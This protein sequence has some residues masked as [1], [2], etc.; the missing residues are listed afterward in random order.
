MS[1][2]KALTAIGVAAIAAGAGTGTASAETITMKLATGH[3]PALYYVERFADY[4]APQFKA[5]VEAQT[6]HKVNVLELYSGTAVKVNETLEGLQNGIVDVGGVAYPF[7]ASK[8]PL[9]GF[10]VFLPF[11]PDDPRV[12]RTVARDVW[13]MIPELQGSLHEK[14]AQRMI[15]LVPLDPYEIV[16]RKPVRK[17]EDMKGL[18]MGLAGPNAFWFTQTGAVGVQDNAGSVYTGLQTGVIDASLAFA[19]L[20]WKGKLTDIAKNYTQLG[21][22]SMTWIGVHVS[23]RWY[24]GLPPEVQQV[25]LDLGR[26]FEHI[27]SDG[28][29]NAYAPTLQKM[30]DNGVTIVQ[31]PLEERRKWAE[32]LRDMPQKKADELEAEGWPAIATFNATL[33]AA[34]RHGHTWP[35]RYE[36][37]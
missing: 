22:S 31:L 17:L 3:P 21:I 10:Q 34:E 14:Y 19:S 8:L 35:V 24:D 12:S 9:H 5:R 26:D 11:S 29:T 1:I 2:R 25:L 27:V 15:T 16:S 4:F 32:S 37:K 6:D 30:R 20:V 28:I 13:G 33:D 36:V 18:K 7:E 23:D